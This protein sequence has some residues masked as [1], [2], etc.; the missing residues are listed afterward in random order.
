MFTSII[1]PNFNHGRFVYSALQSLEEQTIKPDEVIIVD[2]KSTDNSVELIDKALKNCKIPHKFI[3]RETNSALKELNKETEII[4][5]LD[6]DDWYTPTKIEES[7]KTFCEYPELGVVYSDYYMIYAD[8]RKELNPK[9]PY[10]LQ[11]LWRECIV[12]ANSFV[13]MKAIQKVGMFDER[14]DYNG[15]FE[16]YNLWLRVS[17]HFPMY[18]IAKPLFYY[19]MHA[20]PNDNISLREGLKMSHKIPEMIRE[21]YLNG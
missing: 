6:A 3:K 1:I 2:D 19:R 9:P 14:K 12:N 10:D 7:L 18:E 13:T 16:D 17:K 20:N 4:G 21:T 5:F 11:H 8:G 15:V